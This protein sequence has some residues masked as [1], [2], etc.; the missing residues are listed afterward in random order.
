[1]PTWTHKVVEP[2]D[3]AM[4]DQIYQLGIESQLPPEMGCTAIPWPTKDQILAHMQSPHLHMYV[5]YADGK[6]RAAIAFRDGGQIAF[7]V[8]KPWHPVTTLKIPGTPAHPL[9][10][11]QTK[12]MFGLVREWAGAVK[13]YN[14]SQASAV[15]E[16]FEASEVE[17]IEPGQ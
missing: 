12:Y 11:E 16:V 6:L 3:M 4:V 8:S 2:D 9:G 14:Q 7:C 17:R 10:L 15:V 1:M 13:T 5:V